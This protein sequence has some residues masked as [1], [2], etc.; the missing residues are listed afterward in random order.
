VQSRTS[1]RKEAELLLM[2]NEKRYLKAQRLGK[3]GNW[4]YNIQSNSFWASDAAKHIFGF[5]PDDSSFS[6]EEVE[7]CI[8]ERERVHSAIIDLIKHGIKYNLEYTVLP[9][10]GGEPRVVNSI[11]ELE[12]DL[13]GDPFKVVGVIL[14]ITSRKNS[15]KEIQESENKYRTLVES[16][17]DLIWSINTNDIITFVNKASKNVLGYEPDELIGKSFLEFIPNQL[18]ENSIQPFSKTSNNL[19]SLLEYDSKFFHKDGHIVILSTNASFIR[20]E[21]NSIIGITGMSIDITEQKHAEEKL[22]KAMSDLEHS[23]KEL[24][25]FAYVASH[26]LQEPLRMVASYTQ[27]LGKR[28]KDKLDSDANDFIAF[29]IDGAVRMQTLINDL[30]AFS[31]ISSKVK[32]F[33]SVNLSEVL[34]EALMSLQSI[35]IE[36]SAIILND[37]LPSV[38][39]DDSQLTRLFQNLIGNAIK[40]RRDIPPEI[41]ISAEEMKSEWKISVQDNGIGIEKDFYEKIFIIFQRLHSRDKYPGT[42]IGLAICKRI[43]EMHG[44]RIWLESE[45]GHGSTFYFTIPIKGNYSN[46]E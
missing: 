23:N 33:T 27:L 36:N 30:L 18:P 7:S 25:Q 24:E 37:N 8:P 42:G 40:Y 16:S 2:E 26:D 17:H 1:D 12:Y 15:E 14:D 46:D 38:L 31:R 29:A 35:I 4:E 3:V 22:L 6:F 28:Y 10:N 32:P 44:G 9:K 19:A 41:H 39:G 43:V 34:G 11:G 20:D 21:E 13:N 5:T 45:K